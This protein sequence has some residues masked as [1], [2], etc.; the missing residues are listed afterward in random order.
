MLDI[1][2]NIHE[3]EYA[4]RDTKAV[5][6][7]PGYRN[8]DRVYLTDY[9]FSYRYCPTESHKQYLENPNKG[10]NGL[11]SLSTWMLTKEQVK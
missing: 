9:G 11:K 2:E 8:P 3:D 10:H 1:L 7:L 6:L 4:H 5:N